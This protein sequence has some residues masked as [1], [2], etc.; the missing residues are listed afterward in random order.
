MGMPGMG[1]PGDG[2]YGDG[3]YGA[4]M[5]YGPTVDYLLIRFFDFNVEMGKKYRYRIQLLLEDPNHPFRKKRW[6]QNAQDYLT[7]LGTRVAFYSYWSSYDG[8]D[9]RLT[10]S[11]AALKAGAAWASD[12][13]WQ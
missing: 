10:S 3:M 11:D 6:I 5:T 4:G 12:P 1:M 7:Q 9:Y 8:L 2:M 13:L